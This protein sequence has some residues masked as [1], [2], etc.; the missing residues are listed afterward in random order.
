MWPTKPCN[1]CPFT[2]GGC[3]VRL[4]RVREIVDLFRTDGHFHCHKHL[5]LPASRRLGCAGY[6]ILALREAG[7]LTL[8]PRLAVVLG[9]LD[10]SALRAEAEKPTCAVFASADEMLEVHAKEDHGHIT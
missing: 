6:N 3:K 10:L 5:H 4:G 1:D 9:Y 7:G 2:R 8:V